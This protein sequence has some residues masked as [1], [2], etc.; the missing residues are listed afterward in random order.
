VELPEKIFDVLVVGELNVDLI[1]NH[2]GQFPQ[3]GKEVIARQMIFTLGSSSAIFASNLSVL[4][5]RVAFCGRVGRDSFAGKILGDLGKKGVDTSFILHSDSLDTGISVALNVS[6]DRAMVTYPGAMSE[7]SA[8]EVTDAMLGTAKHLHVS[9]V[10]LQPALQP[11]LTDLFARARALGLTTSLDPQWD[12]AEQWQ[13]NW[14]RLLPD[15]H[16]FLPNQAEL[17]QIEAACSRGP[18][19]AAVRDLPGCTVVKKGRAG[20]E[21]WAQG[22]MLSQPAFLNREV[23]DAIGAGDSFDAGFIHSFVQGSPPA[24]CL[25]F[26]ALCGAINTTAAGGTTAFQDYDTVRRIARNTFNFQL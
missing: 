19:Q 2:L 1:L 22:G 5:S 8:A 24:D 12:P 17:E 13:L 16:V 26:G 11:G 25:W 20:A 21:L 9:S 14:K 18:Q 6:E 10:F 7:L 15:V 23:V 4:G 3:V